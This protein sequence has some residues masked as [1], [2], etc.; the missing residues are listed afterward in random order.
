MLPSSLSSLR[1]EEDPASDIPFGVFLE[2]RNLGLFLRLAQPNA[3]KEG[4]DDG[5]YEKNAFE[6]IF[7]RSMPRTARLFSPKSR[8]LS[9]LS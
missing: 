8:S 5:G 7:H 9:T 1:R 3:E 6:E 2:I 4:A